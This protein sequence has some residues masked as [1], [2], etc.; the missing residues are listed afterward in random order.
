MCNVTNMTICMQFDLESS[1]S[2]DFCMGCSFR[3]APLVFGQGKG[4]HFRLT[5]NWVL[6]SLFLPA[7]SPPCL[8]RDD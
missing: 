3:V 8:A 4:P 7:P 6:E 5:L 2:C 1:E